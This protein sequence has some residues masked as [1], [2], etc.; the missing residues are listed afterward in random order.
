MRTLSKASL[1]ATILLTVPLLHC[2]G[3]TNEDE[4]ADATE[5]E[6]TSSE[7]ALVTYQA[8]AVIA[9]ARKELGKPYVWG[10]GN[11]NGPTGS[12][13]AGFDCS[14]LM[15]YSFWQGDKDSLPRTSQEQWN[16][17]HRVPYASRKPGDL[18]FYNGLGH[19][20]LYIG[21]NQIIEALNSR[22]PIHQV[23]VTYPGK[24]AA[25]VVRIGN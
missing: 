4:T 24:P 22:T 12:P 18:V 13:K 6:A 16:Y 21:N 9:A 23:S 8:A 7:D 11:K 14:G 5:P 3:A 20:A 1:F 25:Y 2:S 19:V 17:G 10:G 15:V